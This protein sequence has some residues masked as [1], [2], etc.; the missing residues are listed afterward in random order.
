MHAKD[1]VE[2]DGHIRHV[3][4]GAQRLDY[5]F[6]LSL[7]RDLELPLIAH[8]LLSEQQV[9]WSFPLPRATTQ[10][11]DRKRLLREWG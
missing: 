11:C 1:V 7:L 10:R 2:A 8:G 9:L 6:Y 5:S 4:A 3:A